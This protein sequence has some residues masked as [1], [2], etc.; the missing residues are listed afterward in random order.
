MSLTHQTRLKVRSLRMLV[1]P[2]LGFFRW[3]RWLDRGQ[4]PV[5]PRVCLEYPI[6]TLKTRDYQ[7]AAQS[8]TEPAHDFLTVV[9]K[10]RGN[11]DWQGVHPDIKRFWLAFRKAMDERSIPFY[12]FELM[13]SEARQQILFER[14]RSKAKSGQSP[15]QYGCAIDTVHCTRFWGLS[16]KEW[17]VVGVIGKEVARKCNIKM[18]WGGDW[19]FFDP[20]HWQLENWKDYKDA[21]DY[22]Q[23]QKMIIPE[24]TN[25]K[26]WFLEDIIR[27]RKNGA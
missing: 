3:L 18:S 2:L 10:Q 12:A 17:E 8:M 15:H 13:R 24:E 7:Q 14:G 5:S 26:F 4:L 16:H 27:E 25:Q 9:Q 1:R 22:A 20:V 19:K 6:E 11:E 21:H 23:A